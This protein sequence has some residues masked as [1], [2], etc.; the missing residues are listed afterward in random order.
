MDKEDIRK[1]ENIIKQM[2][3]PLKNIPLK[4]VIEALSGF[5]ILPF[6]SKN[7]YDQVVLEK[8]KDVAR[9][10]ETRINVSGIKR[11]RPN[12]VGNAVERFVKIALNDLGYQSNTPVTKSG[13]KK[14][15]GYPDIEFVDEFGRNHY[16]E[17]KTFNIKKI[18]STQRSFYLSPSEDFKIAKTAHH[19]CICFEIF[20]DGGTGNQN[21]YKCK[22]WKI[23][24]VEQL[25][26]DVKYEFNSDNA[27]LYAKELLL[28]EGT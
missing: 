22:Q 7:E 2:R 14:S 27:R 18:G 9:L 4:L 1:L 15:T 20:A 28:A 25:L 5:S 13:K 11:N 23:L 6:D 3:E 8:L 17:C 26:V 24:S 21:I 12:E 16:L 19:F 10:A